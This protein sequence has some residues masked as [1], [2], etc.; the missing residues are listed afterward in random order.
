M[1]NEL[2]VWGITVGFALIFGP[3]VARSSMRRDTVH[4]GIVAQIFHAL[5]CVVMM[6]VLP[7]ILGSI[8]IGHNA[9]YGI[10]VAFGLFAIC[11]VLL[12][13]FAI[14]EKAPREAYLK[15]IIPKEDKGWTAED[16]L[17]SGL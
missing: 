14:F 4:G 11:G 3:L 13:I 6:M 5:A 7:L 16:A 12:T 2:L 15:T 1:N 10:I 17:K 8:F 9:G